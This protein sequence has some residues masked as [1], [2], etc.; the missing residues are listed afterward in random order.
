MEYIYDHPSAFLRVHFLCAYF[1][2]RLRL[3]WG[4]R[5]GFSPSRG[6]LHVSDTLPMGLGRLGVLRLYFD[7][8]ATAVLSSWKVSQQICSEPMVN[9]NGII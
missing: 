6:V 9:S 8:Q 3:H 1:L 5:G 4:V 7:S 2:R